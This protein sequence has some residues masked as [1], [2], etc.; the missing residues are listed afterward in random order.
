[1]SDVGADLEDDYTPLDPT[2][3][4]PGLGDD[5]GATDDKNGSKELDDSVSRD[6]F[7]YRILVVGKAKSPS[8]RDAFLIQVLVKFQLSTYVVGQNHPFFINDTACIL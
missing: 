2:Y 5:G 6:L 4:P 3:L 8:H 1:M 7:L